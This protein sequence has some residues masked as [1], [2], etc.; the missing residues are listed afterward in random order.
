M[1]CCSSPPTATT[2]R[3]Y[4]THAR[5]ILLAS[6]MPSLHQRARQRRQRAGGGRVARTRPPRRPVLKQS[7]PPCPAHP[8]PRPPHT[9]AALTCACCPRRTHPRRAGDS[10]VAARA[11]APPPPLPL[12][13]HTRALVYCACAGAA[14][15][16]PAATAAAATAAAAVCAC[17]LRLCNA[18]VRGPQFP[19]LSSLAGRQ[20]SA[21]RRC[22]ASARPRGWGTWPWRRAVRRGRPRPSPLFCPGR[23]RRQP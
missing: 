11:T 13:L 6:P 15:S 2:V 3:T 12:P 8:H 22:T 20:S 9:R 10:P 5:D 7:L 18:L 1:P 21:A 23:L 14:S 16:T 4:S 19:H 17:A